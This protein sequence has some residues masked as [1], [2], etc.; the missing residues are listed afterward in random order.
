MTS[1]DHG[2]YPILWRMGALSG[3]HQRPDRSFF[4]CGKQFPVCARCTGAALGQLVGALFFPW[5]RMPVGL[6]LLLC[7]VMF[8]DWLLQRMNI[9]ESTNL[10]RFLTGIGCG[11]ALIQLY[12]RILLVLFNLIM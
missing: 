2:L 8:W 5:Y 9:R 1:S 4:L 11:G 10:R 6:C 3:C 12:F 7:G